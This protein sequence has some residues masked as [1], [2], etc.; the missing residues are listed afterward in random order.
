MRYGPNPTNSTL[1]IE[2]S[3]RLNSGSMPDRALMIDIETLDIEPTAAIV[4]IGAVTFNPR[5]DSIA[6]EDEFS[7][8]IDQRSN[9]AHGRSV[10]EKT[11]IWWSNQS[12][13]AQASVFQGP[14]TE[15]SD[16]LRQFTKWVNRLSPTCTR[17]WAKDPDFDIAI[18][19]HACRTLNIMWPFAFWE[20]RSVRTA[21][22]MA[23]P[24]G[25]FPIIKASG[26]KHDAL[27]DARVQALEIQHSHFVLG[28]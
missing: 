15:L 25:D 26:P 27:V 17:V 5:G 20:A 14:H 8:T 6:N 23:Y 28:C 2:S 24:M 4:A 9:E 16:A 13:E 22:E 18:L 10:S 21:M 19:S 12:A 11:L 3:D 1:V 7:I